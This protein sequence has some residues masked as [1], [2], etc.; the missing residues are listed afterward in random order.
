[1]VDVT[2]NTNLTVQHKIQDFKAILHLYDCP[3]SD[4]ALTACKE[5]ANDY[6][7]F[8][9][10]IEAGTSQT[11]NRMFHFYDLPD[12]NGVLVSKLEITQ[13]RG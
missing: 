10:N 4:A 6:E 8:D 2:A 1:M 13:L 5:I 3:D 12:R 11:F 7:L 9:G